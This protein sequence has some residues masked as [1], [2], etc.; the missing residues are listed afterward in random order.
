MEDGKLYRASR[1]GGKIVVSDQHGDD[2]N[3]LRGNGEGGLINADGGIYGA[4]AIGGRI[5]SCSPT[6]YYEWT[7][8]CP[9]CGKETTAR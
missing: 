7:K 3:K 5:C 2:I 1:P 8:S 9:R 6:I 4:G